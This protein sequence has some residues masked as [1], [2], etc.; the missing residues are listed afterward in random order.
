VLLALLVVAGAS[1][2]AIGPASASATP[3]P[4]INLKVLLLGTS[5]TQ[6]D[7]V[8]WQA[9]LQREGVPFTTILTSTAGRPTISASS[10]S[11]TLADGTP[12]ANYDAVIVANGG[13]IA[14]SASCVSGLS[15]AEWNALEQYEKQFNIRQ[16]SGDVN[17][18]QVPAIGP[19]YGTGMNLPTTTGYLDGAS[20]TLTTDGQKVFPYLNPS[21]S[22]TIGPVG[23]TT[24][25]TS[26][27]YEATPIS[28]TNFDPLV[29]EP[30]GSA[31]V[32]IYT[33][34][35]G[36]QELVET[37]A[38]NQF[39]LQDQLLRHGAIAWVT[40]G[41]YFGDQRNY[42]ETNIDDTFIPDDVWSTTNHAN[43]YTASVR[44]TASDVDY[45]ASWSHANNFRIDNLF[46][47]SGGI[48]GDA[49]LAEFKKNDPYTN[50]PYAKSFGWINHT[51]DHPSL[52]NGCATSN[53]IQT[54]IRENNTW[55]SSAAG[56]GLTSSTDPTAA[57][58][59]N[60]PGIVVT[61][62]HSGLANLIP[63]NPGTVD[64]PAFDAATTSSTGGSLA[65]GSYTYAITDQFSATGG[66]SSASTTVAPDV[67]VGSTT[68]SVKL[69]WEAVCHAADYKIYRE[70]TGSNAWSLV[71][72]VNANSADFGDT[73]PATLSY[74][75]TGGGTALTGWTPPTTNAATETA[76]QQNTNLVNAFQALGITGFGSDASKPY[77]NPANTSAGFSSTGYT[78]TTYA[79]G[80]S[81][82]EPGITAT[83]IPRY[84]TNIY[85]N[86]ATQAE[87]VDEYNQIY[88]AP[89]TGNCDSTKTTCLPAVSTF[90]DI[91][92]SVANGGGGMFQHMMGNDPRPDYFHQ[93]NMIGG[94]NALYYS[95]MNQLLAEYKQ[96]FN[97]TTTPITQPTMAQIAALLTEQ[98][99]WAADQAGTTPTVTGYIQGNQV[100]IT[101][102]G[103]AVSAMP[104]TGMSINGS[105][106]GS[107]Y[108]GTQSGWTATPAA[109]TSLTYTAQITWPVD[110]L[111]VSLSPTAIAANGIATSTATA[112]L[113]ADGKPVADEGANV[114]FVSTDSGEK[115]SA[116]T[117]NKNG[118]YTA[119]ITSSTTIGTPT[120]TATDSSVAPAASG[121]AT[122]NQG[123]GPAATVTVS[124]TPTAIPADGT[125][126]AT[127]T[128]HVSD[129]QGHPVV[130]DHVGFA[131]GD[132]GEKISTTT[133]NKNGTYTATITSST[134]IGTPT[135]TATDSSVT[136]AVS[137]NA[138]LTQ[139]IGPAAAVTVSLTPTAILANG[140]AQ[141]TATAHVSDAG[142]HAIT[143]DHV[144][145]A[146]SDPGE[147]ISAV[148]DDQNG[149]YTATIT[150]STAVGTATI[151][152]TDSSVTPAPSGRAA[153][154]QTQVAG[155]TPPPPAPSAPA[156]TQAP[157]I[158][159][160][161]TVGRTLAAAP[162]TWSGTAPIGYAYQ[163]Q[164]CAAAC[165]AIA[166]ATTSTYKVTSTDRR[167]R[168]RVL[169]T[170]SN[171]AGRA[172]AV[173]SQVG[174]VANTAGAMSVA[175]ATHLLSMLLTPTGASSRL[176]NLL[177]HGGYSRVFDMP[178]AGHVQ[179]SWYRTGR[180][181]R[182][183][184]ARVKTGVKAGHRVRITIALTGAG[185]R[186]LAAAGKQLKITG[187]GTLT[188]PDLPTVAKT[189]S[190][191]ITR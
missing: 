130:G 176:A 18:G 119:T 123:S 184:L 11:S 135:I 37:Y 160:T 68:G 83:A 126:Q 155:Q 127:A 175:Q 28:T 53:F 19:V 78:G 86:V 101:N 93:S 87:E 120:I 8:D 13:L 42:V 146:T 59:N 186:W 159:G 133:D 142:G 1:G 143:G 60:N 188:V 38:Q 178:V 58:G 168:L 136:P 71:T 33:H 134:T 173:S 162:G 91:V 17:P 141:S 64:P 183:L 36:V 161:P 174:P 31:L 74:T 109:G 57:L 24:G 166:R 121:Q 164:R 6:S 190:F 5:S 137:G 80:S 26:F 73:G 113:T 167:A 10:L 50:Q 125:A 79:A 56:L 66:E 82:T 140:T 63:G 9:A 54:E 179:I 150:S 22:I 100:T 177:K 124:L 165:T 112:T 156:N 128:A 4:R 70:V 16:I 153:L 96:Y 180:G 105:P 21:A 7:L 172:Q 14:C 76:Y 20:G 89:P 32:G 90:T 61:G 149:S 45:A 171:A 118:T 131:S 115:V 52:D 144:G 116:T 23:T 151:T 44:E 65:A 81:F 185:R 30:N 46:N 98:S 181:S 51:W 148:T 95:V 108:G 132:P 55:A 145:F 3:L 69:S 39:L 106:V 158:S 75:D 94:A 97:A 85:Y 49:L 92:N 154:T 102:T 129:A 2:A 104:L 170:A 163:W 114:K 29:S 43:D 62:E 110:T 84:P 157:S 34:P 182:V 103:G 12:V 27:G 117:D 111:T 40:R 122:L 67:A 47:G 189:R 191:A 35:D 147:K 48:P 107:S 77:P 139:G 41:V 88:V 15:Q 138:T 72:T 169:V 25:S 187:Q 99:K 152:A